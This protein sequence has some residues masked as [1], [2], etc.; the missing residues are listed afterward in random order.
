MTTEERRKELIDHARR[1]VQH[2][3]VE[4]RHVT[5]NADAGTVSHLE[6][7]QLLHYESGVKV[8][9]APWRQQMWERA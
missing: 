7:G 6:T 5:I 9:W 1:L 3:I 4:S 8:V 2:S